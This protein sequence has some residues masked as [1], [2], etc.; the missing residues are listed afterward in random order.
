MN[1][2]AQD[3]NETTGEISISED[4]RRLSDAIRAQQ[5]TTVNIFRSSTSTGNAVDIVV[6]ALDSIAIDW[7]GEDGAVLYRQA[8]AFDAS[9]VNQR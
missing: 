4:R 5:G 8:I 6:S 7:I 1:V 9:L 2:I 3:A